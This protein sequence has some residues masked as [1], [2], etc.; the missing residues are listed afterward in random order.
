MT[1]AVAGGG[2][3]GE[4]GRSSQPS[5]LLAHYHIV[6]LAYLLNKTTAA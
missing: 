5:W 1:I 3:V 4:F 2:S 6:V